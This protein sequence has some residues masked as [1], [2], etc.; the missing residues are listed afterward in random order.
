M[1]DL[2]AILGSVAV[3][4]T[5]YAGV[6]YAAPKLD[7]GLPNSPS[8]VRSS[9]GDGRT[10]NVAS[11]ALCWDRRF[12]EMPPGIIRD[13]LGRSWN[14]GTSGAAHACYA[15]AHHWG[16][17][18][19]RWMGSGR[20][21]VQ[22][23]IPQA[24]QE[25]LARGRLLGFGTANQGAYDLGG[26]T[27]ADKDMLA[28]AVDAQVKFATSLRVLSR[29]CRDAGLPAIAPAQYLPHGDLR[30]ITFSGNLNALAG[31]GGVSRTLYANDPQGWDTMGVFML[32]ELH[33]AWPTLMTPLTPQDQ[34]AFNT[35]LEVLT[36]AAQTP[37]QGMKGSRMD[38]PVPVTMGLVQA[39]VVLISVLILVVGGVIIL[40]KAMTKVATFLGYD[41]EYHDMLLDQWEQ[42]TEACRRGDQAACTRA[43]ALDQR[44][45]SMTSPITLIGR[46]AGLGVGIAGGVIIFW[47]L[48]KGWQKGKS[49]IANEGE[50][51]QL[52]P[53]TEP[54]PPPPVPVPGQAPAPGARRAVS[55]R[56]KLPV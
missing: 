24:A 48:R 28:R 25:R 40:N 38:N 52:P 55:T 18:C 23:T 10:Y 17:I 45:R 34:A 43:M 56:Q 5:A 53:A 4:A 46:M 36:Q 9:R 29:A 50:A 49:R 54:V 27:Q 32:R 7:E 21:L 8:L 47:L 39:A 33:E 6:R 16:L 14:W 1:F 31:T 22:K 35:E 12:D 15:L 13:T 26:C 3:G 42:E 44:I 30:R 41:A 51:K 11:G 37:Q 20:G 2:A 19:A